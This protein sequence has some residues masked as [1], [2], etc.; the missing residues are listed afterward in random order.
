MPYQFLSE[1]QVKWSSAVFFVGF[2]VHRRRHA[3]SIAQQRVRNFPTE[4][5]SEY[6][7][8]SMCIYPSFH[9]WTPICMYGGTSISIPSI[10]RG[11]VP[12]T[13]T[14]IP[15]YMNSNSTYR[16]HHPKIQVTAHAGLYGFSV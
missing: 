13:K 1:A 3:M 2:N 4:N 8:M 10:C 7:T 15:L 11:F 6:Y 5:E 16:E 12:L 9:E 14:N